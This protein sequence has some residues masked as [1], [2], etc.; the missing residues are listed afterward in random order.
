MNIW[1]D[2]PGIVYR[3]AYEYKNVDVPF[4]T[5]QVFN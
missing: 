5:V 4:V 1:S 3:K 2:I